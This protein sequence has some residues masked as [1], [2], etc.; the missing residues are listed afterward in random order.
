KGS[1]DLRAKVRAMF[2]GCRR[3]DTSCSQLTEMV[4]SDS[5]WP[6]MMRIFRLLEWSYHDIWNYIRAIHKLPY[7]CLYDQGYTSL[8][9]RSTTHL[10]P[11]LLYYDKEHGKQIYRAAHE[12]QDIRLERASRDEN[13]Q[14]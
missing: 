10:N 4:A 14:A 8:G 2:L 7:C 6:A 11:S 12:L 5:G 1:G 9:D 13:G 3:T